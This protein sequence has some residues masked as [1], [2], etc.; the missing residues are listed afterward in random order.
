MSPPVRRRRPPTQ[1]TL[2][3]IPGLKWPP[4]VNDGHKVCQSV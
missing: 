3:A 1:G 4:S 2:D